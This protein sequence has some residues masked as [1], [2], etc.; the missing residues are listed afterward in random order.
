MLRYNYVYL[1]ISI[2][3]YI[4]YIIYHY[5]LHTHIYYTQAHIYIYIYIYIYILKG[6]CVIIVER[7]WSYSLCNF[8]RSKDANDSNVYFSE[9]LFFCNKRHHDHPKVILL[10]NVFVTK[11]KGGQMIFLD[12]VVTINIYCHPEWSRRNLLSLLLLENCLSLS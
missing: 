12:V 11:N 5:I 4:T 8:G 2:V 1:L 6:N 10:K 3:I 7:K 9:G